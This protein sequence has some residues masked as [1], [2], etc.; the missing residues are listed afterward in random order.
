M[1]QNALGTPFVYVLAKAPIIAC[2]RQQLNMAPQSLLR[3]SSVCF[4]LPLAGSVYHCDSSCSA[5]F[6]RGNIPSIGERAGYLKMLMNTWQAGTGTCNSEYLQNDV[7]NHVF[8]VYRS[9][10]WRQSRLQV[11]NL[12]N[13]GRSLSRQRRHQCVGVG[14]DTDS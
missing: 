3:V 13:T 7:D 14:T 5:C 4:C 2:T 10:G 12:D 6:I 11:D 8:A 9:T 1:Y